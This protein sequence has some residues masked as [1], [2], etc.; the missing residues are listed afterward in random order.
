MPPISMRADPASNLDQLMSYVGRAARYDLDV[1]EPE[2]K[3]FILKLKPLI[4]K[5]ISCPR[6]VLGSLSPKWTPCFWAQRIWKERT[7]SLKG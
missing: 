6:R 4:Q 3:D 1:P 2:L 5:K 7:L